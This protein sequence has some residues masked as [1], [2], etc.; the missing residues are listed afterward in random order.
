MSLIVTLILKGVKSFC[1]CCWKEGAEV[2]DDALEARKNT[3]TG[4]ASIIIKDTDNNVRVIEANHPITIKAQGNV[5][6]IQNS[7]VL[8]HHGVK[9]YHLN[10][11]VDL[12]RLPWVDAI[13]T[14]PD[15]IIADK[16]TTPTMGSSAS[17][18]A[19]A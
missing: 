8:H 12:P 13:D 6:I 1:C 11:D 9:E 17:D 14:E 4:G 2:I 3:G 15:F 5:Q 10:N 16:F 7:N 18:E 19:V